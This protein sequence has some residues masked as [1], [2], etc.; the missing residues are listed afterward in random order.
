MVLLSGA[1]V[2]LDAIVNRCRG[3]AALML[4]SAFPELFVA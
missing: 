2:L 3:L 1:A 4:A